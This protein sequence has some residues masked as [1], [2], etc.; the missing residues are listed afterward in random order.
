MYICICIIT[1][2]DIEKKKRRETFTCS[3]KTPFLSLFQDLFQ[4]S[5]MLLLHFTL[6][7]LCEAKHLQGC[8]GGV[9][10]LHKLSVS[11]SF[12]SSSSLLLQPWCS[13]CCFSL[14]PPPLSPP[15]CG[16]LFFPLHFLTFPFWMTG[17]AVDPVGDPFEPAG[18]SFVSHEA[19]P[20]LFPQKPALQS[21]CCQH[22]ETWTECTSI[23]CKMGHMLWSLVWSVWKVRLSFFWRTIMLNTSV[24]KQ[25]ARVYI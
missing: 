10:P 6:S 22:L 8:C 1:V 11:S 19:A 25:F 21:P 7:P 15:A 13:L 12:P 5:P 2:S 16:S 3:G 18:S 23:L 4:S 17:S 20:C 14:L 9:I 24:G